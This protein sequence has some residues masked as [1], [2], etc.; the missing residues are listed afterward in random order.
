MPIWVYFMLILIDTLF[1]SL[2]LAHCER[3]IWGS[4]TWIFWVAVVYILLHF[5]FSL[6]LAGN[7]FAILM[8][9]KWEK[10]KAPNTKQGRRGAKE[11]GARLLASTAFYIY[12]IWPNSFMTASFSTVL[13]MIIFFLSLYLFSVLHKKKRASAAGNFHLMMIFSR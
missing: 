8:A 7:N 6:F 4:F 11:K 9:F 12:E 13:N 2:V 3:F 5:I 1:K 10:Y